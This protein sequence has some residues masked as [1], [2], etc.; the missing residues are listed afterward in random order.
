M[1]MEYLSTIPENGYML[2]LPKCGKNRNVLECYSTTE[3]QLLEEDTC[4]NTLDA[5]EGYLNQQK[6]YNKDYGLLETKQEALT[7]LLTNHPFPIHQ[8]PFEKEIN[9]V[10]YDC[11][12]NG[13][14]GVSYTFY[15]YTTFVH[16]SD[17]PC[18]VWSINSQHSPDEP[19]HVLTFTTEDVQHGVKLWGP[20]CDSNM[21]IMYNCNMH[22]C[23]IKCPC[24]I[25][26]GVPSKPQCKNHHVDLQRKFNTKCH[27]F[28]IPCSSDKLLPLYKDEIKKGIQL[29]TGHKYPGIPRNCQECRLDLLDHQIHHHVVHHRCKFCKLIIRILEK[30]KLRENI[31]LAETDI[32]RTDD[33]T[34]GFCYKIFTSHANRVLHER[35]AH[36]YV[37]LED[38]KRPGALSYNSEM[39]NKS[40]KLLDCSVCNCSYGDS[41]GLQKHQK[42]EH[43]IESIKIRK[44]YCCQVCQKSYASKIA[45][46]S[47]VTICHQSQKET[48]SC[49]ICDKNFTSEFT[50]NR[51]QTRHKDSGTMLKCDECDEQFSRQDNLSRHKKEI[52][53]VANVNHHYSDNMSSNYAIHSVRPYQCQECSKKFKRKELVEIHKKKCQTICQ[54]CEKKF[55]SRKCLNQHINEIH[56]KKQY[57]CEQCEKTFGKQSNLRRHMVTTHQ[58]IGDLKCSACQKVFRRKDNMIRHMVAYCKET[59]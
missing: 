45:L 54:V 33:R 14:E 9:G 58:D 55:E 18:K 59:I 52:H 12:V 46:N 8:G 2:S 4:M 3:K 38:L 30:N 27:S 26:E 7:K 35:S 21:A 25:C 44:P 56:E 19:K 34:C 36:G 43:G 31:K 10:Q 32:Q 29:H 5:S 51:H 50:L 39:Y 1:N 42:K 22:G 28:T 24:T 41:I 20:A 49:E 57:S 11:S 40:L 15:A 48:Y 13:Q 47:H 37:K 17:Q 53:H 6:Y 16:K 23:V